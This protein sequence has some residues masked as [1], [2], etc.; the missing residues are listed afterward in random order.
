MWMDK[1][2]AQVTVT[3]PDDFPCFFSGEHL[4]CLSACFCYVWHLW[5]GYAHL[6][7]YTWYNH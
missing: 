4:T 5:T 3:M 1:F 7:V 6:F 2:D